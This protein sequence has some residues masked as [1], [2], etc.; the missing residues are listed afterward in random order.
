M[1]EDS[2]FVG[3]EFDRISA[4]QELKTYNSELKT[5]DST[6]LALSFSRPCFGG[7]VQVP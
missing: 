3:R 6:P 7:P 1:I 2:S 5:D 4:D